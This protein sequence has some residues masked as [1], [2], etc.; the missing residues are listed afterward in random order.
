LPKRK[1]G[2]PVVISHKIKTIFIFFLALPMGVWQIDTSTL[3]CPHANSKPHP[4]F[5]R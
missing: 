3:T 4:E 1:I 5:V 2:A